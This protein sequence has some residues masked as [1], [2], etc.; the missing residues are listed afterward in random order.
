MLELYEKSLIR[1]SYRLARKGS[2]KSKESAKE[3]ALRMFVGWARKN[4]GKTVSEAR[5]S[6]A[7]AYLDELARTEGQD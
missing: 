6:E 7:R 1:G 3:Q 4:S 5:V 2:R